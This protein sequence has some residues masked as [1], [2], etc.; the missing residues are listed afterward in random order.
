MSE[1]RLG[2]HEIV[3]AI[4][5]ELKAEYLGGAIAWADK[6]H[7]NAWSKAIDRF[8]RALSNAIERQDYLA[9]KI[10]GDFYKITIL[11]LIR[12]YKVAKGMSDLDSLLEAVRR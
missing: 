5:A 7:D 12:E 3:G 10:E 9:A 1:F 11:G 4:E 8:D 6:K 2:F